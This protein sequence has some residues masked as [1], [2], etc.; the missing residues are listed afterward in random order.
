[1]PNNNPMKNVW[2]AII[3]VTFIMSMFYSNMLMGEF[4][5]SGQG[6]TKGLLWALNDIFTLENFIIAI[7]TSLLGYAVFE[8]LRRKL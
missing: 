7:L 5:R 3:E 2:R 6:Q 8:F 4:E 1:M